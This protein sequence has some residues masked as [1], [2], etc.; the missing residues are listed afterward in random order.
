MSSSR[1]EYFDFL[2]GIAILF[3][4]S[5][6]SFTPFSISESNTL[7]YHLAIIWRQIIGCAVPIFLAISGYFMSNKDV[8]TQS[9]YS[10]CRFFSCVDSIF[11]FRFIFRKE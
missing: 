8:N 2:R 5:I 6:H 7:S 11:C 4:I 9:K 1:I 10:L 3:V